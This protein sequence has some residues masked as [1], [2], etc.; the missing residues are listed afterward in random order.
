MVQHELGKRTVVS[1]NYVGN[2][3]YDELLENPYLNSFGFGGLPSSAA[4]SRVQNVLQLTNNGRS[5]YNGVTAAVKQQLG[6]GFSGQF[7]YTFSHTLDNVSNGGID[8]YSV[9]DSL[10]NQISPFS[11]TSLNY[12]NS[13]YDVRHSLNAS[14]VWDLPVKFQNRALDTIAGGWTVS[15]TFF[16]RTGLPFSVVDGTTMGILQNAGTNLQNVT[17]LGQPISAV[18]LS[19]G[20]ASVNTPCFS[21]SQFASGSGVTT[22]GMIPRNSFRGPGFFNTDL[23][24]KKTFH[25]HERLA[26]TVGAN[27]YNVLNHVNYANPISNLASSSNFGSIVSAVQPPTSPY[28]AFAAAATDARIVQVM[29]KI[30]F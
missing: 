2:H 23:G 7:S 4:D 8:P 10:L 24:L 17:V 15:G 12:S 25:F 6:H 3:G 14:Y 30:T 1:V 5:N 19:C 29:G 28:G 26:F 18:P 9:N 27:A 21:E 13:D 22:F 11:P 20:G 16:Y